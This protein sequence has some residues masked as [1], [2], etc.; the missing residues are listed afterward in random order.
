MHGRISVVR[1]SVVRESVDRTSLNDA[2]NERTSLKGSSIADYMPENIYRM[3]VLIQAIKKPMTLLVF[4]RMI[5][6]YISKKI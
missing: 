4:I 3:I 2:S 1:R 5:V 6:L